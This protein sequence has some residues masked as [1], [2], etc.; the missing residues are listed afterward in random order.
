MGESV[1]RLTSRLT[2]RPTSRLPFVPTSRLTSRLRLRP[3]TNSYPRHNGRS[4]HLHHDH[5]IRQEPSLNSTCQ[6]RQSLLSA[7]VPRPSLPSS[8]PLLSCLYL[9][10][11]CPRSLL[12]SLSSLTLTS[13]AYKQPFSLLF[14]AWSII[15]YPHSLLTQYIPLPLSSSSCPDPPSS[16]LVASQ[17]SLPTLLHL[18]PPCSSPVF[19]VVSCYPVTM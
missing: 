3:Y 10:A 5:A 1:T 11:S 2:S 7:L 9:L 19:F 18:A 8:S 14:C 13:K 6:L 4:L 16:H 12:R 17:S 15:Q